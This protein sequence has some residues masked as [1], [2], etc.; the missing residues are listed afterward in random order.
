[1]DST[2]MIGTQVSKI[3][4]AAFIRIERDPFTGEEVQKIVKVKT[5][6]QRKGETVYSE[7]MTTSLDN[8]GT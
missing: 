1:M 8:L 2:T 6:N 4:G 3:G 7:G 5:R